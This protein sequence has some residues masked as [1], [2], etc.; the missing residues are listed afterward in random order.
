[1]KFAETLSG[2]K[3]FLVFSLLVV[4]LAVPRS[5]NG[6][7]PAGDKL[8]TTIQYLLNHVVES[9]LTFIRNSSRYTSVEAAEHM[10][11][12]YQH[13][14]D[15]IQTADDFI[16]LCATKSLMSGRPYL[17]IDEHGQEIHTSDW[18]R[19]ALADYRGRKNTSP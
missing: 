12:K 9:Q 18:L 10:N 15:E 8:E 1:M 11:K 4:N 19:A 17:V 7:E 5:G 14:K 3:F 6:G 16:R 2:I 13:F